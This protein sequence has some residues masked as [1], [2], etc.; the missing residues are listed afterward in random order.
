MQLLNEGQ[1]QEMRSLLA[2]AEESQEAAAAESAKKTS[3]LVKLQK[4]FEGKITQGVEREKE[5]MSRIEFELASKTAFKKM[6]RNKITF[7]EAKIE[8]LEQHMGWVRESRD[9]AE[10]DVTDL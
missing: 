4:D 7:F 6:V 10:G 9:R 1:L 3:T 5:L 2:K 8:G